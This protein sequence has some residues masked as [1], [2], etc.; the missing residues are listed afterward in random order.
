MYIM[1]IIIISYTYT[2][3][4][5]SYRRAVGLI[6]VARKKCHDRVMFIQIRRNTIQYTPIQS[7][8]SRVILSCEHFHPS[9]LLSRARSSCT[10]CEIHGTVKGL[11]INIDYFSSRNAIFQSSCR[12]Y[13]TRPSLYRDNSGGCTRFL[14]FFV[15]F[16]PRGRRVCGLPVVE[17]RRSQ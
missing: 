10:S 13:Y 9:S 3:N 12:L 5:N 17:S 11:G 14:F 4:A 2:S 7:R 16:S 6:V 1:H 8:L 15:I